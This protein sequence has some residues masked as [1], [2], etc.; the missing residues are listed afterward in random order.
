M[1]MQP[2]QWFVIELIEG[3]S[4]LPWPLHICCIN[5]LGQSKPSWLWSQQ[6]FRVQ[7]D[8]KRKNIGNTISLTPLL[9]FAIMHAFGKDNYPQAG[10]GRNTSLYPLPVDQSDIH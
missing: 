6:R 10:N 4:L 7:R 9:Q 2:R 3:P 8:G 5:P 1:N